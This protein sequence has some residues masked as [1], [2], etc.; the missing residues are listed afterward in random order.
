MLAVPTPTA[1]IGLV[2]PPIRTK[3]WSLSALL[4]PLALIIASRAEILHDALNALCTL[5]RCRRH[6]LQ[7]QRVAFG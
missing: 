4:P 7:Q 1:I 2:W 3:G 6:E 5:L